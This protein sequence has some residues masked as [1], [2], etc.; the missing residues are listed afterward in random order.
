MAQFFIDRPVFAW[1]IAILITLGGGLSVLE[2]PTGAY[3]NIAPPQVGI[4]AAYP[5]ADAETIERTVTQVIEQQL[6]GIDNVLYFTSSSSSGVSIRGAP[7]RSALFDSGGF[8][9][10]SGILIHFR[11]RSSCGTTKLPRRVLPS[12]HAAT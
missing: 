3:P 9:M 4:T 12:R 8:S 5:G 2:L 11:I 6:T 10:P 1:V 7:M